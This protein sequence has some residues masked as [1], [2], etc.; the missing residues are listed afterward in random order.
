MNLRLGIVPNLPC[1]GEPY[2]VEGSR[3]LRSLAGEL[4]MSRTRAGAFHSVACGSWGRDQ[5][6]DNLVSRWHS[7]GLPLSCLCATFLPALCPLL[8]EN[9]PAF[10]TSVSPE[11]CSKHKRCSKCRI[12]P[13]VFK[14]VCHY[15]GCTLKKHHWRL[16]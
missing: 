11:R 9:S 13:K 3:S 7:L 10:S 12:S 6:Q 15:R 14:L 5:N 4:R 1:L 16:P 8:E 2:K